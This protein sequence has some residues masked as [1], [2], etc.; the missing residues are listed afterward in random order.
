MDVNTPLRILIRADGARARQWAE[1]LSGDGMTVWPDLSAM[2]PHGRPEVILTDAAAPRDERPGRRGVDPG[3]VRVAAEGPADARLPADAAP[4]EIVM[5]CQLVGRIVRL[6]SQVRC[7]QEIH[8]QLFR[9]ALSDPITGLPNR[10]AWDEW[11][12]AR[13]SAAGADAGRLCLAVVDLDGFKQV[14]D[15]FGHAAGDEVLRVASKALRDGLRQDD[16][17]A[18][19]GGDEF[20]LLVQ[21]PSP[22]AAMTIVDR[23]RRGIG[24]QQV[25]GLDR[26]VTAS[27]GFHL[28]MDADLCPEVLLEAADAALREAKLRGRNCT[29]GS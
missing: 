29:V 17:L 1:W 16:L 6:R 2:P 3:V 20:G 22:A 26:P 19:L 18:R 9:A 14:N 12:P 13:L 24:A 21:V 25:A 28:V 8:D 27:A 5:A 7:G 15:E 23:V 11:L 4:R 10:R